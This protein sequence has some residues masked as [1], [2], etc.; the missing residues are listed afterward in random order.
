MTA[1]APVEEVCE[2]L[3]GGDR[4]ARGARRTEGGAMI[5]RRWRGAARSDTASAYLW[6]AST[7]GWRITS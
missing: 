7:S 3:R 4:R 1:A 5:V 6:R 2:G